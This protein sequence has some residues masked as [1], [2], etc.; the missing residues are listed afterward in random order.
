MPGSESPCPEQ[1]GGSTCGLDRLLDHRPI[2]VALADP[3]GAGKTTFHDVYLKDAGLRFVIV[4]DVARE[5]DLEAYEAARLAAQLRRELVR[6]RESFIFE[7]VFSDPAGDKLTFLKAAAESG[8]TVVVC[9]VGISGP[10]ISA[11]RVAM[12]ASLRGNF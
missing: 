7:T 1:Q 3:I 8:Y 9:F 5:L 11:Q 4:D 6:Q 2:V 12:R 10:E